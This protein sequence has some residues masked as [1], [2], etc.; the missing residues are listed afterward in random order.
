MMPRKK[1]ISKWSI[2]E[3]FDNLPMGICYSDK[4]DIIVLCNRQMHRLC[5]AI[6]GRDLQ[7]AS[8]LHDSLLKPRDAVQIVDGDSMVYRLPDGSI[9]Q[10]TETEICTGEQGPKYLQMEAIDVTELFEKRAEIERDNAML[11]EANAR[12]QRLFTELDEIVREEE[13]FAL[14]M[15]VHDDMG[16]LLGATR[17]ILSQNDASLVAMRGIGKEWQLITH[18]LNPSE[19]D[20]ANTSPRVTHETLEELYE[21]VEG[22]GLRLTISGLSDKRNLPYL[23]LVAIRESAI[24][25]V[26][27]AEATELL[28]NLAVSDHSIRAEITNNGEVP[29]EAVTEGGGLSALRRRIEDAGGTMTIKSTP[30]FRLIIMLPSVKETI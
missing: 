10:F 16:Q 20:G 25:A 7:Y 18:T 29:E 9:W 23:V 12:T 24:N 11:A 22:I 26:R 6:M 15:R 13:N 17:N 27:H 21:A 2:K 8:E 28:V 1:R 5:Y 30:A 4:N 3:S 14:K 19:A